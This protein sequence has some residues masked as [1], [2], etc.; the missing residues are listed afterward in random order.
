MTMQKPSTT[1][2][3]PGYKLIDC[4]IEPEDFEEMNYY[5][6]SGIYDFCTKNAAAI[7]LN[8]LL[9]PSANVQ[10]T[11]HAGSQI[12]ECIIEGKRYPVQGELGDVFEAAEHG[13]ILKGFHFC[14][15]IPDKY[16]EVSASGKNSTFKDNS[17]AA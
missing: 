7:A 15:E 16:I 11:H 6:D 3:R 5:S 14:V 1:T 4:E 13:L 17:C 8:R 2:L 12:F 10:I 9:K